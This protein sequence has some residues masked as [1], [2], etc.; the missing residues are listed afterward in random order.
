[1]ERLADIFWLG[2][3]ELRSL[4]SDMVMVVFVIY[5]FTLAIYIQATGTSSEVNNA[6]IAFVDEDDSAL[7]KELFNAFYPPR[8]KYPQEMGAAQSQDE[9]DRGNMMFVVVIPPSFEHD[10]RAGRNPTIQ[11]NIDA[12]AM[13][14]AAIGAGYIRSIIDDRVG[15]FLTRENLAP[16]PPINLVVRKLFN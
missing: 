13:Q 7:S 8:F 5:A 2:V 12:T 1:M 14:Q 11:V 9:M 15:T 10:L 4:L 6:S 3:K 16:Q